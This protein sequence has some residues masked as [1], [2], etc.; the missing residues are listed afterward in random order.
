MTEPVLS[1]RGLGVHAGSGAALLAGV[2]LDLAAGD[3]LAVVGP[4]GAGK[5]MLLRA[6]TGFLPAGLRA[7]GT[8]VVTGADGPVELLA[9]PVEQ[10]QRTAAA[11]FAVLGQNSLGSLNPYRTVG[12][13]LGET[14]RHHQP[15]LSRDTVREA[16]LGWLA[17][18]GLTDPALLRCYPHQLSGGM[19]Q[20]VA[21]SLSLCGPQQ[22]V[23]A[24]EPTT[25]LDMVRQEECVQLLDELGGQMGRALVHVCHDLALSARLCTTVVVIADGQVV[26]QGLL[27]QV[28]TDPQHRVTQRLLLHTR[29]VRAS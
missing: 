15:G 10:R 18:V 17:R 1:V 12:A 23:V 9:L 22:I 8:A 13:Q 26:E 11:Q 5:S 14:L 25:A 21:I 28:F 20:R 29:Q 24:D 6:V 3:R 4:S 7:T 27:E 19:R 2:D 16:S